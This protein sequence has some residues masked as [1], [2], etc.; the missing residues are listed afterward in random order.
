MHKNVHYTIIYD[1][2]KT[3]NKKIL[4]RQDNYE[5]WR[6]PTIYSTS[7]NTWINEQRT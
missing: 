5:K 6:L 7:K 4:I 3:A 1:S 2:K